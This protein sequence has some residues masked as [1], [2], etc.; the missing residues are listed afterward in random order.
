M[1]NVG[2]RSKGTESAILGSSLFGAFQTPPTAFCLHMP[3]LVHRLH[4]PV[5]CPIQ[6][7]LFCLFQRLQQVVLTHPHPSFLLYHLQQTG[8]TTPFLSLEL[9]PRSTDLLPNPFPDVHRQ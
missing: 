2:G 7:M 4:E 1:S 9:L 3:L 6:Q 5:Y 8:H